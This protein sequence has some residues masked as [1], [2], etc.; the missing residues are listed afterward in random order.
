MQRIPHL[1]TRF[2]ARLAALA[3]SG[4]A[5]RAVVRVIGALCR[6]PLPGPQDAETIMPPV[7]RYWFRRVPGHNL[8]IYFAF[9]DA[10]LYLVTLTSR[11]PIPLTD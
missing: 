5:G 7:A 2:R 3:G 10:T 1:G 4:E 9:D 11:P 6:E 8:W